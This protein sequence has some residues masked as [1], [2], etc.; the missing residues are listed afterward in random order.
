L[1]HLSGDEN[2]IAAF[3]EGRDIHASTARE[4]MGLSAHEDVPDDIRR[5]GKTINFGIVYGMGAF[6]LGKELGIPVNQASNYI[7]NYFKR[8]PRVKEYFAKLEETALTNG[9]VQTIYGRKRVISSID[10]SGRDQGF[11]MRAA[12]NA[13]LQGSAADII[14]L[15]MINVDQSLATSF[16]GAHLILQIHD[17][18]LIEAPD[19]G[20]TENGKLV[21]T[22]RSVMESVLKL[23]VP[24][25]VDASSG[26]NWQESQG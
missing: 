26:R 5:I 21:E 25:K 10:T 1:A 9:E 8:Y 7:T 17:E 16:P 13:P 12:I 3:N 18:L 15:A 11:A 20:E 6:R 14:K 19:R 4:I 24:L 23:S 2:L 22:V